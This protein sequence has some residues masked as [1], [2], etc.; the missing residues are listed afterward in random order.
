M[1]AVGDLCSQ[2]ELNNLKLLRLPRVEQLLW[3]AG[4]HR[5]GIRS[6]NR[7]VVL[8]R[9]IIV[10]E[11]ISLHLVTRDGKIIF[12]K[13][14]PGGLFNDASE[15]ELSGESDSDATLRGFVWTYIMMV[16]S[17]TDFRIALEHYLLPSSFCPDEESSD[18]GKRARE[19]FDAAYQCWCAKRTLWETT[20]LN[21]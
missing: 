11:D 13:P 18:T 3:L 8:G 19:K 2:R 12:V 16:Q 5:K 7:Q 20:I 10:S 1:A 4:G 9:Q 6:L 17:Q 14:L 15:L 21:G